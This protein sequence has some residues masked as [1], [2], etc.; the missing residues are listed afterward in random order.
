MFAFTGSLVDAISQKHLDVA[1]LSKSMAVMNIK[2][3]TSIR[4]RNRRTKKNINLIEP[5]LE[6]KSH[7]RIQTTIDE[8]YLNAILEILI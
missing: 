6:I 2:T 7:L 8:L 5:E 3:R 1:N 4:A